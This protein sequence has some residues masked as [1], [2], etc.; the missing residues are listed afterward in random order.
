M[1]SCEDFTIAVGEGLGVGF[2][3]VLSGI[4]VLCES[5]SVMVGEDKG[6]RVWV[7]KNGRGVEDGCSGWQAVMTKINAIA[8]KMQ[9]GFV[10]ILETRG[11]IF[12]EVK[13]L[14]K[15][16]VCCSSTLPVGGQ[17]GL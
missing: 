6:V 1:G 11:L 7:G 3:C 14:G 4:G 5:T 10:Q 9:A 17:A 12:P 16:I 8:I 15:R 2:V 13:N